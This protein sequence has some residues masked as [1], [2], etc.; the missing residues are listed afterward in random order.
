MVMKVSD[1][2]ANS[3]ISSGKVKRSSTG[4]DFASFLKPISNQQSAPVSGMTNVSSLDAI[5]AT[6][7]VDGIEEKEKKKKMIKRGKTL[8][9]KLDDIQVLLVYVQF[10]DSVLLLVLTQ[11]LVDSH[12]HLL[13]LLSHS[14][15]N[16][17][18]GFLVRFVHVPHL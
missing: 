9:D 2:N 18:V 10:V 13:L 5:F 16:K 15:A 4:G 8:L 12:I 14:T 1:I 11:T 6:Q 17:I 7:M 3:E